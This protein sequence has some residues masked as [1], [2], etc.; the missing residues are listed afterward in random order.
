MHRLITSPG[1]FR[2]ERTGCYSASAVFAFPFCLARRGADVVCACF[3]RTPHATPIPAREGGLSVPCGRR[4]TIV[5][6]LP[7]RP[8][9]AIYLPAHEQHSFRDGIKWAL[10]AREEERRVWWGEWMCVLILSQRIERNK[11]RRDSRQRGGWGGPLPLYRRQLS[12][13]PYQ[14]PQAVRSFIHPYIQSKS[15][16]PPPT[17][18]EI[19]SRFR[20]SAHPVRCATFPSFTKIPHTLGLASPS[21]PPPGAQRRLGRGGARGDPE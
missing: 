2:Q 21:S 7:G 17:P 3:I 10:T 13:Q 16:L 12:S 4:N 1:M 20:P 5:R 15:P 18:P 14:K 11:P 9:D 19:M 8:G 6:C